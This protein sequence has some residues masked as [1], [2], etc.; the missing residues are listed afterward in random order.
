[1]RYTLEIMNPDTLEDVY[2]TFES[3]VPFLAINKGDLINDRA[4]HT[5]IVPRTH[6]LMVTRVEHIIWTGAE[7]YPNHKLVVFTTAVEA[8]REMR[9]SK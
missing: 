4:F 7:D 1:M 6:V 8:T 3:D 5:K 9:L 2:T